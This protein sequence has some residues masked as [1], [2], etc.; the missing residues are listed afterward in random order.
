ME[1]EPRQGSILRGWRGTPGIKPECIPF[2]IFLHGHG[3]LRV[4]AL[5]D[6]HIV[7]VV[8]EGSLLCQR[9]IAIGHNARPWW[10]VRQGHICMRYDGSTDALHAA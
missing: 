3:D 5:S 4:D 7:D 6:E 1:L 8:E 10:G 9:H 2:A